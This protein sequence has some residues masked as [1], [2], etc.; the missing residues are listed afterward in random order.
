MHMRAR[1][2]LYLSVHITHID[3]NLHFIIYSCRLKGNYGNCFY[4]TNS[5][6]NEV[7]FQNCK[8]KRNKAKANEAPCSQEEH[9]L[10]R[11]PK[12]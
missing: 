4:N 2:V 5:D 1:Y 12:A 10:G 6:G 3:V 7:S 8:T 11:S 9:F